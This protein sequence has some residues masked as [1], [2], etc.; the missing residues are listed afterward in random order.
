MASM[1]VAAGKQPGVISRRAN[2]GYLVVPSLEE[3]KRRERVVGCDIRWMKRVLHK[4]FEFSR[5]GY[6]EGG[7]KYKVGYMWT[8]FAECCWM[9]FVGVCVALEGV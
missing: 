9:G 2:S 1:L 5:V 4:P 3:R 6:C 7:M 8:R